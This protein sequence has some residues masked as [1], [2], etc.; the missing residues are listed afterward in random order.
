LIAQPVMYPPT[1]PFIA[2]NAAPLMAYDSA[3]VMPPVTLRLPYP[4]DGVRLRLVDG[5][6]LVDARR[7]VFGRPFDL[8]T[9]HDLF[10]IY[11]RQLY[12]FIYVIHV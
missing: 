5:V 7:G 4:F 2:P 12:C 11:E 1:A 3:L 8:L 10:V 6:R 9:R